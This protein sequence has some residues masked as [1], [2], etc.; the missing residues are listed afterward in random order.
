MG[1]GSLQCCPC[2]CPKTDQVGALHRCP[3]ACPKTD[4]VGALQ[5]CP[6][7]CPKTDQVGLC[8]A[9]HALVLRQNRWGHC[10]GVH[11]LVRRQTRWGLCSA[12]HALG[13][14]LDCLRTSP[15]GSFFYII[16]CG[17]YSRPSG[18]WVVAQCPSLKRVTELSPLLLTVSNEQCD[19]K[20]LLCIVLSRQS[21]T[22]L[23]SS[24]IYP[25]LQNCSILI[26]LLE[27][28]LSLVM[29][30]NGSGSGSSHLYP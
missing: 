28:C 1:V 8:S 23:N 7:A 24:G 22:A 16:N 29:C 27:V 12:V 18:P 17:Q 10:S 14:T 9:V 4:Q 26:H 21:E 15:P 5:R 20:T 19:D 25:V 6:C 11:A 13:L 30:Y 2:A 3:C